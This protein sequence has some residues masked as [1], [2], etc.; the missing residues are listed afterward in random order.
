MPPPLLHPLVLEELSRPAALLLHQS[1]R[2]EN[3]HNQPTEA[4]RYLSFNDTAFKQEFRV[5]RQLFDYICRSTPSDSAVRGRPPTAHAVQCMIWLT[6]LS[7]HMSVRQLSTKFGVAPSVAQSSALS[8]NRRFFT[9]FRSELRWGLDSE[10]RATERHFLRDFGLPHIVGAVDGTFIDLE[11]APTRDP[12]SFV[13]R[14]GRMSVVLQLVADEQFIIRH[15]V[16]GWPGSTADSTVYQHSRVD[17]LLSP[18]TLCNHSHILLADAG[19]GLSLTTLTPYAY[20]TTDLVQQRFNKKHAAARCIVEM[21]IG[22]LKRRWKLLNGMNYN[23]GVDAA[24]IIISCCIL[25]NL[26]KRFNDQPLPEDCHQFAATGIADPD[27][28][29][30]TAPVTAQQSTLRRMAR[31]Q[32]DAIAA[33]LS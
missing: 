2:T 11:R 27:E 10:L 9:A 7:Q 6:R 5:S 24:Q 18:T 12:V 19:Y 21:T 16:V 33:Q 28:E 31:E 22:Q 13:N 23:W 30:E 4:L 15:A 8:F 26:C 17:R 14:K 20:S 32:R 1:A 3:E 29:E 25:H